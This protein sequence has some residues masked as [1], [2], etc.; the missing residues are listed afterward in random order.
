VSRLIL[1]LLKANCPS[2]ESIDS[3]TVESLMFHHSE[4]DMGTEAEI[5]RDDRR[6]TFLSL[7]EGIHEIHEEAR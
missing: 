2:D 7:S 4:S 1:N 5:S 3:S 6:A